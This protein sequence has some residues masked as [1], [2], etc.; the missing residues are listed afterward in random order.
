MPDPAT[1]AALHAMTLVASL[2]AAAT[3]GRAISDR[4]AGQDPSEQED[5]APVRDW[6][7]AAGGRIAGRLVHLR[8]RLVVGEPDDERTRLVRAF[9]DHVLLADLAL[10]LRTAHQK[11]L[12]L[13][14]AVP[15]TLVEAFRRSHVEA[16]D[17]AEGDPGSPA[18]VALVERATDALDELREALA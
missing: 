4:R 2:R 6:L 12:S 15:E 17:L 3:A 18:L 8:L 10:D 11:L 9:E 7:T 1:L 14:P 5:V 13:Y 16:A